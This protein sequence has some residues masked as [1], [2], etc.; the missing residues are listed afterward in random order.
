MMTR[1]GIS[2]LLNL[3]LPKEGRVVRCR[4]K[5]IPKLVTVKMEVRLV[6]L[7]QDL[8][9]GLEAEEAIVDPEDLEV[10]LGLKNSR[11]RSSSNIAALST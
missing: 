11:I 3:E 8:E 6:V 10:A 4:M 5:M 1:A 7:D 2:S 9:M